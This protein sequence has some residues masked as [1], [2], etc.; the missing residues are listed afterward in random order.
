MWNYFEF[1]LKFRRRCPLKIFLFYLWQLFCS[2]E[3]G[4]LCNF[5]KGHYGEHLCEIMLNSDQSFRRFPLKIL[6]FLDLVAI[7]IRRAEFW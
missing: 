6:Q 7:L 2:S 4:N 1:G 3:K 5:G